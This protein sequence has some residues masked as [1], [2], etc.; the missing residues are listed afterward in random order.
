MATDRKT[1]EGAAE[2]GACFTCNAAVPMYDAYCAACIEEQRL[3]Y[4]GGSELAA[5]N[6][7]HKWADSFL[8]K[9]RGTA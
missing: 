9:E 5:F 6:A 7:Y 2:Q 8:R 3:Q 4:Y 1:S